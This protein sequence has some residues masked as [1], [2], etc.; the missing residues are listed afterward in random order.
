MAPKKQQPPG[1]RP[2]ASHASRG[3]LELD[4]FSEASLRLWNTLSED[5]DE[6]ERT[7]HFALEP[8]RRRLRPEL[9]AALEGCS[10][11]PPTLEDW[12]R[13]VS[14]PYSLNPLSSAGSLRAYGG[15]FNAGIDLE[16]GTL[17][18][19]PALYLAE[20]FETAFREKFQMPSDVLTEGLR[21]EELALRP[22]GSHVTVIVKVC[23]TRVFDMTSA[24]VL[25][26][27]AR[28]L[29]RIKMPN[30]ASQLKKK[31]QMPNQALMMVQTGK[32]LHDVMFKRNWRVLPVQFNLPAQSQTVAELIRAAGF[33]GILYQST[34]GPGK[35][36]AVF[37][38]RLTESSFISLADQ[39]PHTETIQRLD[40]LTADQ[41]AGWEQLPFMGRM[42]KRGFDL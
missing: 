7:L 13:V 6:L 12:V 9:L 16:P 40:Y 2:G 36:L 15:R 20:N 37:P 38:D 1:S 23:L 27:L 22:Q 21:P 32:Q 28:V 14:Y 10:S 11:E 33:E 18:P 29:K 24:T 3:I 17:D 26:P 8:E 19:W 31:L 5:L 42:S 39:P 30:R 35:C 25:D 34:M 4:R 41:L